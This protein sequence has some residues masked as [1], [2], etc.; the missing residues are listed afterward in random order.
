VH[1]VLSRP[2]RAASIAETAEGDDDGQG[3]RTQ[4]LSHAVQ[5]GAAPGPQEGGISVDE[6]DLEAEASCSADERQGLLWGWWGSGRLAEARR[7]S[8]PTHGE[9]SGGGMAC[10]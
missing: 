8:S 2:R 9:S 6:E 1:P 4:G 7:A 5:R 10:F 3:R